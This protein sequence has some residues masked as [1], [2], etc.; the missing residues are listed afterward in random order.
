VAD[1]ASALA[2]FPART[3]QVL[4]SVAPFQ[5]AYTTEPPAG[6]TRAATAGW[7]VGSPVQAAVKAR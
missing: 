7:S 2:V 5:L 3:V 4:T 1:W 6:F